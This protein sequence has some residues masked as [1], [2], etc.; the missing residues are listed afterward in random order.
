MSKQSNVIVMDF[1]QGLKI[2]AWAL[3][4]LLV[5]FCIIPNSFAENITKQPVTEQPL[6]EKPLKNLKKKAVNTSV[7]FETNMG[8]FTIE[9][10]PGKA[11]IT[12]ANFL[13]YI[14]DAFYNDTIF[15]RVIDNFM[16]QGGGFTENMTKKETRP[17]IKIE[18]DNGL[19]NSVGTVA[20][21]R[22][23]NP[24]SATAQFFINVND[25]AFLNH[26]NKSASGWGYTVFGKISE[27]MDTVRAI[28]NTQTTTKKGYQNVPIKP[29]II[30]KAFVE[31]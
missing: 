28:K 8:S 16:V 23:G 10:N 24:N 26:K 18:A 5:S 25:N 31:K 21:A 15:H 19:K 6:S 27:G 3:S 1:A 2:I 29:I 4:S 9:L 11:P 7:I 13:T 22:T 30:N 17:P 14:N 20:M 12:V